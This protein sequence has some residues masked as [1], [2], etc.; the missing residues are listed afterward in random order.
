LMTEGS[1]NGNANLRGSLFLDAGSKLWGPFHYGFELQGDVKKLDQNTSSFSTT[2]I[3]AYYYSGNSAVYF[4]S[5]YSYNVTYTLWDLDLSPRGYLSFDLGNKIQ[6]LTFLGFNYN[7]QTLDYDQKRTDGGS[8]TDPNGKSTT[9]YHTST[10][11]G[12]T[13]SVVAGG[14]VSVG[15]FYLDYTRFLELTSTGDYA[16]NSYNLDRLGLGV[17]LRF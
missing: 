6:L 10:N 13:W 14:R 8:F 3:T 5:S 2:D 12:G 11:L 16:W 1:K 17:N 9:E 15:A 4:V 7:W